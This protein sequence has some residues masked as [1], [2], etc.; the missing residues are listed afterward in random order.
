M[1]EHGTQSK[2]SGARTSKSAV[3]RQRILVVDDEEVYAKRIR[4]AFADVGFDARHALDGDTALRLVADWQPDLLVLDVRMPGTDGIGV[5]RQLRVRSPEN[6]IP[7]ILLTADTREIVDLAAL[8]HSADAVVR[9]PCTYE[10][11]VGH[12]QRILE[13]TK[14]PES[15][16]GS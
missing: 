3:G 7:V 1:A 11:V 16:G 15:S 5:L 12:A 10:E 13:R 4:R 14:P 6:P 2:A 9:K 8:V